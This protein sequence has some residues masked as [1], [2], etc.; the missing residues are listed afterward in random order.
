MAFSAAAAGAGWRHHGAVDCMTSEVAFGRSREIDS[1][2][3]QIDSPAWE[4][5]SGFDPNV[6]RSTTILLLL[7]TVERIQ[8]TGRQVN[9][10]CSKT[11][12]GGSL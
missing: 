11:A 10:N 2:F 7:D 3:I 4:N 12:L 1:L 8:V 6:R 5:L 9:C